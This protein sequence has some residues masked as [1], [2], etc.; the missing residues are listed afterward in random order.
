M[1]IDPLNVRRLNMPQWQGGDRPNYRIG[2]RYRIALFRSLSVDAW[3][4]PSH[5]PSRGV[6][7]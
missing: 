2:G 1:A 4:A 3:E 5:F 7:S 6:L